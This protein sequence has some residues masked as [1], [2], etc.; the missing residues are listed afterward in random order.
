M[1]W[2]RWMPHASQ[3][4]RGLHEGRVPRAGG[5]AIWAGLSVLLFVPDSLP[6]GWPV[7]LGAALLVGAISLADDFR[8]VPVAVRLAVQLVAALSVAAV[9][10]GDAGPVMPIIAAALAIAWGSNLYNFMDGSDGLAAMMSI[11]GFGSL[12]VAAAITGTPWLAYAIV[13][14]ACIPFGIANRPPA[15]M[16]MGDVGSVPLGF[17]AASVGLAGVAASTWPA[18][19]PLLV[20]LPFVADAS[21][22]LLARGLRGE[23]L[24]RAHREHYYQRLNRLGAGHRGTLAVYVAAMLGCGA[25]ALACLAFAPGGG[26]LALALAAG[27]HLMGFLAID[28]HWRNHRLR[29][30]Q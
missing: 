9:L 8:G 5:L 7:A 30:K 29:D 23:R 24:W 3:D 11:V 15:A 4:G 20:F 25:T 18:W 21:V 1:H 16:F 19:F 14:C 6:F 12:G 17:L 13:V 28:Y 26:A 2:A 27:F 10:L 22:T